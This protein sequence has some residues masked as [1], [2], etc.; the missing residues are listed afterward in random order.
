MRVF[1]LLLLL[2]TA[3]GPDA[4]PSP[5][6]LPDGL[7]DI[8]S[9]EM[10]TREQLAALEASVAKDADGWPVGWPETGIVIV[11]PDGESELH[12]AGP[13]TDEEDKAPRWGMAELPDWSAWSRVFVAIQKNH[14]D[15]PVD[16][17]GCTFEPID[18][19]TGEYIPW[20]NE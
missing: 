13:L 14:D 5:P 2:V 7:P 9:G 10:P 20:E 16:S 17:I 8:N 19:A 3:C 15:N 18:Y 11:S 12:V 1:Q 4:P 6:P